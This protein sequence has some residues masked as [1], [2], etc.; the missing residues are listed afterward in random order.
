MPRKLAGELLVQV[1]VL[2]FLGD[3][4]IEPDLQEAS[5]EAAVCALQ[6]GQMVG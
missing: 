3:L 1:R 5:P 4:D 2:V 6:A